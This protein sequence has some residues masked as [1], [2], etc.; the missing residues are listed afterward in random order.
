[1]RLFYLYALAC[2]CM[3]VAVP[4]ADPIA[5]AAVFALPQ[6]KGKEGNASRPIVLGVCDVGFVFARGSTE[7]AP[8]V[9]Q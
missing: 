9:R 6:G 2:A 8:L 4:V 5:V 7:P 1:M 3:A